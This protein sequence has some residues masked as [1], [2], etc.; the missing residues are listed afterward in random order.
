MNLKINRKSCRFKMEV[1][2]IFKIILPF[3]IYKCYNIDINNMTDKMILCRKL[4]DK[5]K[6]SAC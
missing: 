6:I 5:R 1:L 3:F 2:I 4:H